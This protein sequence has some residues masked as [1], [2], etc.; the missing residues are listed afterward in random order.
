MGGSGR[1]KSDGQRWCMGGLFGSRGAGFPG[2]GGDLRGRYEEGGVRG[3]VN[4]C[5]FRPIV[6]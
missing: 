3:K 6:T 1:L 5:L 4:G 2:G